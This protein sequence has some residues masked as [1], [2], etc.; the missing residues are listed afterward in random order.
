VDMDSFKRRAREVASSRPVAERVGSFAEVECGF[1]AA[2]AQ[3]EVVRCFQCG[4]FPKRGE[5]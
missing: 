4:L 5:G 2:E 3:R 1:D